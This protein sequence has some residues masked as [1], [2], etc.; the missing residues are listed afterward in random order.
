MA[1]NAW[2]SAVDAAGATAATGDVPALPGVRIAYERTASGRQI[3]VSGAWWLLA[4]PLTLA[5]VAAKPWRALPGLARR[6][7]DLT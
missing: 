4:L 3:D 7:H 2:T 1:T 5:L 6:S